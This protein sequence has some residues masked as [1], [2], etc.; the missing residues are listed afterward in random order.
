MRPLRTP[1]QGE[2]ITAD[3][4]NRMRDAILSLI[5]PGRGIR[6]DAAG[7]QIIVGLDGPPRGRGTGGLNILACTTFPPIPNRYTLISIEGQMWV[8]GPDD[9]AW[10]PL[11]KFTDTEGEPGVTP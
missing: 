11:Y 10:Y 5:R 9:D 3:L 1:R 4:L 2:T 7:N 8:A 6:I